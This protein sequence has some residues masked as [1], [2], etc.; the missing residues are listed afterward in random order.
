MQLFL[1][2]PQQNRV[3]AL[4]DPAPDDEPI[5]FRHVAPSAFRSL[6]AF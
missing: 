2:D 1:H 6:T 3:V 4:R 5:P